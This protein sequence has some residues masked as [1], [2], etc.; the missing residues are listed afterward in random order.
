MAQLHIEVSSPVMPISTE[1]IRF[2]K[3]VEQFYYVMVISAEPD[4]DKAA[5][6]WRAWLAGGLN[7]AVRLAPPVDSTNRIK[8]DSRPGV[9]GFEVT[10]SGAN[11]EALARLRTLVENLDAAYKSLPERS[12]DENRLAAL[13]EN[14]AVE[15]ELV[16]PLKISL[17][18]SQIA[19]DGVDSFVAM[20]HRGLLA[21]TAR[22]ITSLAIALT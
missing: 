21:I 20:I 9:G 11:R 22:E 14:Q 15:R 4:A 16:R 7:P 3:A 1:F 12:S 17:A 18:H 8:V 5:A 10:V 2:C 6:A 13:T 19:S